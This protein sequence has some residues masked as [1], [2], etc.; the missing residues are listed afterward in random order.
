VKRAEIER[1]SPELAALY[2][3]KQSKTVTRDLNAIEQM[4]L[5]ERG[6]E[7][8]RAKAEVMLGF[9]PPAVAGKEAPQKSD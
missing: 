8:I 1:L 5:I 9:L 3:A 4:G 7:G 6:R 2:A